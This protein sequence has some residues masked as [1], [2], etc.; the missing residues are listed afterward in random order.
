MNR[1]LVS[2]LI[3]DVGAAFSTTS[4]ND[5]LWTFGGDSTVVVGGEATRRSRRPHL[6][7]F[8]SIS[9][10]RRE[11]SALKTLLV[12]CLDYIEF[13]PLQTSNLL[14]DKE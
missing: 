12:D 1:R 14:D 8:T 6:V 7:H 5:G 11:H 13:Q 2:Y 10:A 9:G 4:I 3:G